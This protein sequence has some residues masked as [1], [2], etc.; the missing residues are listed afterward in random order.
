M[1]IEKIL[2]RRDRKKKKTQ[3]ALEATRRAYAEQSRDAWSTLLRS[4]PEWGYSYEHKSIAP[5]KG[6]WRPEMLQAAKTG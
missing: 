5:A 1:S 4:R 6:A 2:S 3:E